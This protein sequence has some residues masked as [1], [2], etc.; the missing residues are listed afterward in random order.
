MKNKFFIRIQPGGKDFDRCM[1]IL[2]KKGFVFTEARW[3][4]LG[5]IHREWKY[6]ASWEIIKFGASNDECKMI[7]HAAGHIIKFLDEDLAEITLEDFLK[8]NW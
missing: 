2:F 1:R 3:K 7:L 5:D 4:T 8:L 6:Y